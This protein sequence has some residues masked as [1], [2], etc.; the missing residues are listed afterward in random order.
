MRSDPFRTRKVLEESLQSDRFRLS[1]VYLHIQNVYTYRSHM[2]RPISSER[3]RS[4]RS[5]AF[6]KEREN[7]HARRAI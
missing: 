6:P 1:H 5:K 4:K 3:S 2:K 7:E